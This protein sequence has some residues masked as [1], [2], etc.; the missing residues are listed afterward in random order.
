MRLLAIPLGYQPKSIWAGTRKTT[1]KWLV[2]SHQRTVAKWL[3]IRPAP[4]MTNQNVLHH[5]QSIIR[6]Q[7]NVNYRV[8]FARIHA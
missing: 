3:V 4:V 1:D 5:S 2:I 6:N 7:R 8:G